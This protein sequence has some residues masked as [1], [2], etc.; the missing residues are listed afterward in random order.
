MI[1]HG[2]CQTDCILAKASA[3][4]VVN[5]WACARSY[6]LLHTAFCICSW[7]GLVSKNYE[8]ERI[9]LEMENQ[10]RAYENQNSSNTW[11]PA[12]EATR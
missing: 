3:D 7:V 5:S 1:C 4:N 11:V 8:I 9:C 10:Q 2:G 12:P 6:T